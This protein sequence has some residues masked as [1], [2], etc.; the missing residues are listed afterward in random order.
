MIYAWSP[1]LLH[2]VYGAMSVDVFVLPG[3]AGVILCI[4]KGRKLFTRLG[5][6]RVKWESGLAVP[7]PG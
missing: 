3:I 7:G 6:V 5:A 2:E 4:A 1:V